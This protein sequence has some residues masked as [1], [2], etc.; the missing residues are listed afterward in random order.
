MFCEF[1]LL[2]NMYFLYDLDEIE[3]LHN[4]STPNIWYIKKKQ[5]LYFICLPQFDLVFYACL[6]TRNCLIWMD[7]VYI[8]ASCSNI[9]SSFHFISFLFQFYFI[10]QCFLR[11]FWFLRTL[12]ILIS[13]QFMFLSLFD[14]FMWLCNS[15]HFRFLFLFFGQHFKSLRLDLNSILFILF[16]Q[17]VSSKV[18]HFPFAT[19]IDVQCNYWLTTGRFDYIRIA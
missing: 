17:F 1:F 11:L 6:L 9:F 19:W 10:F 18:C 3:K 12:K 8:F 14:V 4:H 13:G 16:F 7:I 2:F 5:N 15:H